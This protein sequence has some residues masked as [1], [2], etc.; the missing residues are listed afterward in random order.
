M[1]ALSGLT[2]VTFDFGNTLVPV[3]R[4][5][6]ERVVRIT[7][8]SAG[9]R[10]GPF[11]DGAFLAA[12]AEERQRQFAEEIPRFREVDLEQ[13]VI[14]VL[15]RLRGMA[16][17]AVGGRWDDDAAARCSSPAE[18]AFVL[19]EYS[20]AFVAAIA[21]PPEVGGL[22]ARL[23]RIYRLG[24]VSNWPLAATIDRYVEA[25]GW[26]PHL[27]AVVVSQRVGAIKPHP[28]IFRAAEVALGDPPRASILHVGDDWDADVQGARGAG[29]RAAYLRS[30]PADSPLPSSERPDSGVAD[31]ELDA[32]A[33]LPD[34][35]S[36]G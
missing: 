17:P 26:R 27:A 9:E 7:A 15:A 6:L 25:A 29:W 3:D 10:C 36:P 20:R 22:L 30:R 5:G 35:L 34:L 4:A 23:A 28:G 1:T 16:A 8:V 24:V 18:R 31:L 21:P 13:R 12:W 14:R 2:T 32:L 19:D 33:E 11:G